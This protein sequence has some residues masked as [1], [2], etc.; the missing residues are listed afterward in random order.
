MKMMYLKKLA[1]RYFLAWTSDGID[2]FHAD[3]NEISAWLKREDL[4]TREDVDL[5]DLTDDEIE[6]LAVM[7]AE[8]VA[9]AKA[10][11]KTYYILNDMDGYGSE[12]PICVD[13]EE[14]ER[15]VR[16][17]DKEDFDEVWREATE[18]EI[19]TYG[20]YDTEED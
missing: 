8:M 9:N 7:I 11:M 20:R 14:A 3:A 1:D 13:R 15:L 6:K 10:E 19:A 12:Y 5:K 18:H 2:D 4:R 17:W 16:E